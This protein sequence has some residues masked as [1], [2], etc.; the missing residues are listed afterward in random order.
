[1]IPDTHAGIPTEIDVLIRVPGGERELTI[2]IECRDHKRKAD[3][4]WIEQI[5]GKFAVLPI[6]RRVAVSRRGFSK[7]ALIRARLHNIETLT[8][9]HANKLDWAAKLLNIQ[10]IDLTNI[11]SA[12]SGIVTILTTNVVGDPPRWGPASSIFLSGTKRHVLFAS[13]LLDCV[14]CKGRYPARAGCSR[15]QRNHFKREGVSKVWVQRNRA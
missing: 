3:K 12:L 4:T 11:E 10:S 15:A 8:L 9:D 13:R 2:G 5:Y 7:T 6:D 1:M 14:D